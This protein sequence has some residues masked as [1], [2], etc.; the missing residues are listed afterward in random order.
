MSDDYD[1][2]GLKVD[3]LIS[4]S[5]YLVVIHFEYTFKIPISE[6]LFVGIISLLAQGGQGSVL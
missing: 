2:L 5:H 3:N 6:T 4:F 1:F